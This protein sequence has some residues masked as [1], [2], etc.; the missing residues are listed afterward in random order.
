MDVRTGLLL[1]RLEF[2]RAAEKAE[3]GRHLDRAEDWERVEPSDLETWLARPIRARWSWPDLKRRWTGDLRFL[4]RPGFAWLMRGQ[5][6]FP[7]ALGEI[8][9]PPWGVWLRGAPLA[10]DRAWAGVVGTRMPDEASK[11]AAYDLG[12]GLAASG[13]V[14]V[15]GLAR[16]IDG[17]A[18]R[19]ACETGLTVGVLGNG[20]DHVSPS[21]HQGLARRLLAVGGTLV[22]EYGPGEPAFGYRFVERNRLIS[23]LART[24]VVVQAPAR[25][26]ALITADFALDQGRDVVVHRDGLQGERGEGTRNLVRQG[27]PII[28]SSADVLA[29]WRE[30]SI[31]KPGAP[32]EFD[33]GER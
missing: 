21:G 28:G 10:L 4:E 29:M 1:G 5:P 33:W 7:A 12:R 24:V 14:V 3:V 32:F 9:D 15:S 8:A 19:G 20:I 16:G 25:S 17:Q 30:G 13:A 18:H 11:R 6:G 22:S 23:G 27:A 31:G 2:L 26:G